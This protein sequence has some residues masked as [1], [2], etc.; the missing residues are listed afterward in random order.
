[1]DSA[2]E[3]LNQSSLT[4]RD[5]IGQDIG[6]GCRNGNI[7]SEGPIHGISNCSP[8]EAEI[9]VACAT[10]RAVATEQRGINGNFGANTNAFCCG[11]TSLRNIASHGND[12]A[13]KFVAR[14]DRIRAW[15][16]LPS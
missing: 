12:L 9:P 15:G 10:K 4:I 3:W 7:L 2:G 5:G 8:V 14:H 1:M 13:R 16:K 6:V 11:T